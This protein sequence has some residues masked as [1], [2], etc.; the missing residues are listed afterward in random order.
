MDK[1][2][3]IKIGRFG[4]KYKDD[5]TFELRVN[6]YFQTC[7]LSINEFFIV[8]DDEK[9]RFVVIDN[10]TL[11]G[12]RLTGKLQD[13]GVITELKK[14]EKGWLAIDGETYDTLTS[15]Q[16][17]LIGLDL[18]YQD[19]KIGMVT[20]VFD[21]RAQDVLVVTLDDDQKSIMIPDV[22]EYVISKDYDLNRV[23]VKNIQG[24]IDL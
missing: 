9:I 10:M 18:F 15:A 11:K 5:G 24:L 13:P 6:S 23:I 2:N 14:G 21:N 16:E 1:H 12:N 22:A 20:D 4:Y 7:F 19:K 17:E 8:I 3:L